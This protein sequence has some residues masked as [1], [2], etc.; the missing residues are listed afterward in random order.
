LHFSTIILVYKSFIAGI[1]FS[2]EEYITEVHI[3]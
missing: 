3:L 2:F 1:F